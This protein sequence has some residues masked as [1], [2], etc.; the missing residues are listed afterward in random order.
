MLFALTL[1]GAVPLAGQLHVTGG[2]GTIHSADDGVAL[3]VGLRRALD[4]GGAVHAG[5]IAVFGN[6]GEGFASVQAAVDL[7]PHPR[8]VLAPFLGVRAGV[9][10]EPDFT[11]AVV[12]GVIG[13][14]PRLDGRLR[15]RLSAGWYRHDGGSGPRLLLLGLEFAP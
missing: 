11:G 15:L 12:G 3:E 7:R 13:L 10:T 9:L 1:I 4:D 6:A 8:A 14:A 5:G 2:A